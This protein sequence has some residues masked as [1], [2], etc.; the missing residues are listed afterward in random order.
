[1][2]LSIVVERLT[3]LVTVIDILGDHLGE[4]L[5][6]ARRHHERGVSTHEFGET[7]YRGDDTRDAEANGLETDTALRSVLVRQ[8]YESNA[9]KQFV[10]L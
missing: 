4:T 2:C 3:Q 1:V 10:D 8:Q 9:A 5:G 7:T 6:I